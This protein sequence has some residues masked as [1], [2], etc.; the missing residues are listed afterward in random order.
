MS[1]RFVCKDFFRDFLWSPDNRE[2]SAASSFLSKSWSPLQGPKKE[3]SFLQR[4]LG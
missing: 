4:Q 2:G 3:A 1:Q